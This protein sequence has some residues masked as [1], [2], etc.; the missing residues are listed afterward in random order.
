MAVRGKRA[1]PKD[2]G[3]SIAASARG[4]A[5]EPARKAQICE[6]IGII[7]TREKTTNGLEFSQ[8]SLFLVFFKPLSLCA[9]RPLQ[10]AWGSPSRRAVGSSFPSPLETMGTVGIPGLGPLLLCGRSIVLVHGEN[11]FSEEVG[12]EEAA[13]APTK[14]GCPRTSIRATSLAIYTVYTHTRLPALG[15]SVPLFRFELQGSVMGIKRP[16]ATLKRLTPIFLLG[17][18]VRFSEVELGDGPLAATVS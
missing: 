7:T 13:L 16:L 8:L 17:F 11:Y 9:R 5:Q 14:V 2:G 3:K 10:T 6:F 4:H 1:F 15:K 18:V 12:G